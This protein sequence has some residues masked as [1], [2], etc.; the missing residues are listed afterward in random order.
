MSNG[1]GNGTWEDASQTERLVGL[2]ARLNTVLDGLH[3]SVRLLSE[4]SERNCEAIRQELRREVGACHV[5]LVEIRAAVIEARNDIERVR[6]DTD[7]RGFVRV[8]PDAVQPPKHDSGGALVAVARVA[9]KVPG[10][11]VGAVLKLAVSAGA[12]GLILRLIQWFTTG[13]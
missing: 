3:E 7:P 13:H 5:L 9:E 10:A 6:E 12:G 11:W 4:R 8:A 2:V 1:N